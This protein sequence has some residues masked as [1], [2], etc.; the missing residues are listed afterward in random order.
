MYLYN[1]YQKLLKKLFFKGFLYSVKFFFGI[2]YLQQ[3]NI[4]ECGIL[5]Y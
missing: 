4:Y 5:T 1:Y 2:V 3:T